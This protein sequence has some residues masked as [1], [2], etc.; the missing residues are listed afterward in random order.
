MKKLSALSESLGYL[1][2]S[3]IMRCMRS[4]CLFKRRTFASVDT[5]GPVE[6]EILKSFIGLLSQL[7]EFNSVE[8]SIEVVEKL[9][10]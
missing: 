3:L 7:V 4:K 6:V 5:D 2:K 1:L 9:N 10:Y 8:P